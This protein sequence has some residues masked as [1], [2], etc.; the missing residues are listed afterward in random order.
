MPQGKVIS[1]GMKEMK[2]T[3]A[4][5]NQAMPVKE[6]RVDGSSALIKHVVRCTLV[7]GK[8][9]LERKKKDK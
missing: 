3:T 2:W 9:A 4:D 8:P 6:Q 7:T 1:L 5:L